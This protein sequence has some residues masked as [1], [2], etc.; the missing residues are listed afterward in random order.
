MVVRVHLLERS[1]P[2]LRYM[3]EDL[4]ADVFFFL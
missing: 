2:M 1:K 4:A 3:Y